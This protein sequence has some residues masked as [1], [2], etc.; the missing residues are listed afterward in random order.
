M[1]KAMQAAAVAAIEWNRARL[2]RIAVTKQH[3]EALKHYSVPAVNDARRQETKA[4]AR[5]R[6]ACAVADPT[7]VVID[8]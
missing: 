8:V 4:K 5:L 6:A 7:S 2:V 3:A 1:N